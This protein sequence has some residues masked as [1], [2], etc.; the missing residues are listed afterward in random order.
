MKKNFRSVLAVVAVIAG[1]ALVAILSEPISLE[2]QGQSAEAPESA[3][4]L[5]ADLEQALERANT[6]PGDYDYDLSDRVVYAENADLQ[7]PITLEAETWQSFLSDFEYYILREKGTE[8]AFTHPLN[9]N[10]ERGIYY[11]RA[12]GQPL[13][14]TDDKYDSG[15]GWPSFTKPISPDA[16]VY[17]EDNSLYSRRIEVVDSLSGSH[18]GHVFSDGPAPTGQR[19]CINGAALVFV[20][21]GETPPPN[22]AL[23]AAQ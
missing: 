14:H 19:Y 15:T 20:A 22:F 21:E 17:I 16:V 1:V 6:T 10:T 3:V 8:R 9:N 12:T 13:F 2:A 23:Q 18:L 4:V 11:S 7:Y 5:D